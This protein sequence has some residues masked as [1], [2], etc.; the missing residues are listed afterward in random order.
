MCHQQQE[1]DFAEKLVVFLAFA[2]VIVC[3]CVGRSVAVCMNT[4]VLSVLFLQKCVCVRACVCGQALRS[5]GCFRQTSL[6]ADMMGSRLS[7]W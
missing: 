5:T 6:P 7:M 4:H 3:L 2:V 1:S